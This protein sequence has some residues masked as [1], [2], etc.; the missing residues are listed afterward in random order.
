MVQVPAARNNDA[1]VVRSAVCPWRTLQNMKPEN[2]GDA[3][4]IDEPRKAIAVVTLAII[5]T[6]CCSAPRVVPRMMRMACYVVLLVRECSDMMQ[7]LPRL[8]SGGCNVFV[9]VLFVADLIGTIPTSPRC[10]RTVRS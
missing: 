8:V 4:A 6:A 5:G 9:V 1:G 10:W 2:K 3:M 7:A